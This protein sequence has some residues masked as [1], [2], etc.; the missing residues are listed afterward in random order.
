[1]K[2]PRDL[3]MTTKDEKGKAVLG[4]KAFGEQELDRF[5]DGIPSVEEKPAAPPQTQK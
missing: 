1:V 4:P 2:D 5:L 3:A